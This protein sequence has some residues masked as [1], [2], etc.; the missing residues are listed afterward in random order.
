MCWSEFDADTWTL[1]KE[2]SKNGRAHTLPLPSSA[3]GM[4]HLFGVNAAAGF[5][6]WAVNKAALDQ[7]LGDAVAAFTL[8]DL[9][10]SAATHMADI[11]VQ[12]HVVEQIL[13]HQSGHRRGVAGIY[14]RSAYEKEVRNAL[15]LWADHVG[16]LV[17]GGDRKI[18][19]FPSGS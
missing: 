9:R 19:A 2:R 1:P 11:G 3:W 10:R 14:N 18:L 17:G 12:P 16:A 15:A 7:W 8:H 13:N 6:A 5:T 4:D